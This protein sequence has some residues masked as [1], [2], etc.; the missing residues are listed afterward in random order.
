MNS[1]EVSVVVPTLKSKS[2]LEVTESLER[3]GFENYEVL[4]QDEEPVTRARNAGIERASAD[5]IVFLDDDS[6]VCQG[7][8][9]RAAETLSNEMAYAGLTVHPYD[10]VFGEH[11]TE[12]YDFGDEPRYVDRFWGCNMGVRREVFETVGGWDENMGWGHEE[13]ELAE[14]VIDEFDIY[15]DPELVAYHPY[16]DSLLDYWKKH[17]RLDRQMPYYW[18]KQGLSGA[19]ILARIVGTAVDP[20]NYLG[21]T[22]RLAAAR[23]GRTL[24]KT[25]GRLVGLT[26]S[27]SPK[28]SETPRGDAPLSEVP[29]V[30]EK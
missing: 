3:C 28:D 17:Y 19:E 16:A 2:E 1:L 21:R 5:K 14:R 12:H 6:R 7:Y 8:L 24:M 18:E 29:A 11:L 4:V 25:T 26:A 10:D 30:E 15:Y 23:A 9:S 20:T 13:K 27:R 22:P